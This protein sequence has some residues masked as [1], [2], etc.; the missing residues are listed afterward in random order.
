[1]Q[2]GITEAVAMVA[3]AAVICT[4]HQFGLS[5]NLAALV[6]AHTQAYD[7]GLLSPRWE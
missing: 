5:Q 7:P 1:M 2:L 4:P 6:P 3:L